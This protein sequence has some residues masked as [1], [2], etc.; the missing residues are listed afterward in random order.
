MRGRHAYAILK[1]IGVGETIAA[2]VEEYCAIAIRLALDTKWRESITAKMALNKYK[3]YRDKECI[4][5]L[6]NFLVRV[7]RGTLNEENAFV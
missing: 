6:E 2:N 7:S 3:A 4:T 1:M 5:G